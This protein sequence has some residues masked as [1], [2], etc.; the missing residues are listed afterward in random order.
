[1]NESK[2]EDAVIIAYPHE[3][4]KFALKKALKNVLFDL[5]S[6]IEKNE[7]QNVYISLC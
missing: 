4:D 7:R 5:G 3:L 2:V 6:E 1:M